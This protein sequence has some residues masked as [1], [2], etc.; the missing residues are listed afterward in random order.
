[1]VK[2]PPSPSRKTLAVMLKD[3]MLRHLI[4]ILISFCIC[5]C[6]DN[7]PK[8][9]LNKKHLGIYFDHGSWTGGYY[10]DKNGDTYLYRSITTCITN[11][12]T[13]PLNIEIE[14]LN[15]LKCKN[16][17]NERSMK[18]FILP[19]ELSGDKQYNYPGVSP[20]LQKYL[21]NNILES[22]SLNKQLNPKE[23]L[24]ITIGVLN[25]NKNYGPNQMALISDRLKPHFISH[26]SVIVNSIS[27]KKP[28]DLFIALD[29]ASSEKDST[30][31]SHLCVPCGQISYMNRK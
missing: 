16:E 21:D 24:T 18:I 14:F 20:E 25:Y 27:S 28:L 5:S 11:D 2:S 15:E 6:E 9:H 19:K 1:M 3:K 22:S 30:C 17:F 13:I 23:E 29:F 12:S 4:I 10:N 26:D 7:E 8:E 31:F